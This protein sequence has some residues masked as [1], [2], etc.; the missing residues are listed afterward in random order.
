MAPCIGGS[1]DDYMEGYI[2]LSGITPV[3]AIF[4][5][6]VNYIPGST[7]ANCSNLQNEIDLTVTV[8]A[9]ESQGLLT[10][11]QAPF[12]DFNGATICS[13]QVIDGPYPLCS[14]PPLE[15]VEYTIGGYDIGCTTYLD[16]DGISQEAC[17]NGPAA[18]GF[19]AT[20]FCAT[21]I[22]SYY[23]SQPF[24]NGNTCV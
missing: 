3:D 20:S 22:V 15:C 5:I 11:P 18:S 2:D 4:T 14:I 24:A 23:G 16:C 9:G 21:S 7:T 1:A 8:Y 17:Y 19:D 6:K 10:C 13:S 12:I